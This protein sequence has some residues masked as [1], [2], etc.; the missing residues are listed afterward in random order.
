MKIRFRHG[1]V[2]SLVAAA[3]VAG[4]GGELSNEE[5][6]GE[7]EGVLE[8]L[9]EEL[10][11]IGTETTMQTSPEEVAGGLGEAEDTLDTGITDLE[12]IEPPGDLEEPHDRLIGAF[13]SFRDAT[14]EAR[15]A[16]EENDQEALLS[17]YPAAA[18]EFQSE[19]ADIAQEFE[20]AGLELDPQPSGE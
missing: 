1:L 13:E 20:E 12:E 15:E 7:V 11:R 3:L 5:Y 17:E 9:G 4:C 18:T 14:T 19:V 6:Q 10:Q 2:G 8:P 16:A